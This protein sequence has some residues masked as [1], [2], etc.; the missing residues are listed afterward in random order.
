[1]ERGWRLD[2]LL[3]A[4]AWASAASASDAESASVRSPQRP[5]H[6]HA[7]ERCTSPCSAPWWLRTREMGNFR[8][9]LQGSFGP[10]GP[11]SWKKSPKTNSQDPTDPGPRNPNGVKN[12]RVP[13]PPGANPLVAERAPWRSSQSRVTG[14]QQ[15][16]ANP[17]RF[18]SHFFCTPSNPCAAPIVTRG[19]G[20]FPYQEVSTR[21]F[22]HSPAN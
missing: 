1:M 9:L 10:F 18:L 2:T 19:E 15:P 21:G 14:V 4:A 20:S 17:Y 13:N 7:Q 6:A 8:K 3:D 11:Q 16:I 5:G 22:R 12:W